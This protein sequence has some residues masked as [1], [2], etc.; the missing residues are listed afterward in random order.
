MLPY[1][2]EWRNQRRLVVQD[3]STSMIPRYYTLQEAAACLLV[4]NLISSPEIFR[5]EV[6]L[7]VFNS[8]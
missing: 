2:D 8:S 5:Q 4:R 6:Q 7:Y 1:G 3:F